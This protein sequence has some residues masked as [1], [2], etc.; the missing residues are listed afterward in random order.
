VR[1]KWLAITIVAVALAAIGRVQW[2][3]W[4][5]VTHP[6]PQS[7]ASASGSPSPSPSTSSVV[8]GYFANQR[9]PSLLPTAPARFVVWSR[10]DVVEAQ[11][12]GL[13][14][15]HLL[16]ADTWVARG[17]VAQD[18][19][20]YN[21]HSLLILDGFARGSTFDAPISGQVGSLSSEVGRGFRL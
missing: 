19:Q 8:S 2:D 18:A 16:L 6:E 17:A 7:V 13:A 12:L 11:R 3:V 15:S 5:P 21:G 1:L 9:S 14:S 10:S 20:T 4:P